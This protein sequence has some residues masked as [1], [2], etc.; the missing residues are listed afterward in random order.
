VAG[1]PKPPQLENAPPG[2]LSVHVV[3][4]VDAND[5]TVQRPTVPP[6]RTSVPQQTV[7]A[8]HCPVPVLPRQ[9]NGVAGL[10]QLGAQTSRPVLAV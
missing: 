7:P 6:S 10:L 3:W 4:Q 2:G 5:E 8:P 1:F 9:S